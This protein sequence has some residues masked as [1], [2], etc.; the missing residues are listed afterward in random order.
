MYISISSNSAPL[1]ISSNGGY[2][3]LPSN[4]Y[5]GCFPIIHHATRWWNPPWV[6][7]IWGVTTHVYDPKNRISCIMIR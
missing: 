4:S 7:L 1:I 6:L 5:H 3:H 2:C